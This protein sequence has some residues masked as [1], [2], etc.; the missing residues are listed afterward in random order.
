MLQEVIVFLMSSYKVPPNSITYPRTYCSIVR[1]DASRPK[2]FLFVNAL[3]VKARVIWV[4]FE[5]LITDFCLFFYII[6]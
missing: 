1:S 5:N 3:E 4:Y 6:W 2:V